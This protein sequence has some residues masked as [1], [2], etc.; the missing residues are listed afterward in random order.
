MKKRTLFLSCLLALVLSTAALAADYTDVPADSWAR[1]SI[2]KA[3]EYGLMN[4]VGE[5]RFGL[6]ET[7]S[8]E[9]FVTILVRMFGWES[10]SGEDAAID[11]AD[12]WAREFVNTAAAN[13]VIDA[14]GKFRPRDAITRREMAVMLVRALGLGELARADANAALPFTDV[15][16][17]RG[18]IAI[19]YEI[20]MTTGATETTFEPESTMNRAMLATVIYRM[21]GSPAGAAK[22][23][24]TDVAAADWFADAVAWAYENG[25]VKGM[26]ATSFAPLQEITREQ[27]AVML[28]R[29]AGLCGYDTS[30]RAS[31]KDFADAAK[32][33]DYAADAMQW[34]V[35]NG[36]LNGTDGKRLDPAGS[37]TRAQ[38][39]AML[40]RFLDKFEA[41]AA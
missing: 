32:V 41:P 15:T 37:A 4:G 5:G 17:Q 21:A 9:Q 31:L 34:A 28:L 18:Y 23:P 12:S 38:C 36:I 26:S 25:V 27:L 13:G 1:E 30:A 40:V 24:F 11:I 20:G 39:A 3:A 7:I 16:A 35:A 14:G 8:R 10:V 19:A 29:Y 33:S 6:G 2:D 22:T